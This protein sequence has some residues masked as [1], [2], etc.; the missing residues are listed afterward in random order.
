[1]MITLAQPQNPSETLPRTPARTPT[2]VPDIESVPFKTPDPDTIP[3]HGDDDG[4]PTT[5]SLTRLNFRRHS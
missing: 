1:M 5:C 2:E 4:G 3:Q